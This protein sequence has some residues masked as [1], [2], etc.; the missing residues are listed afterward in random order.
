MLV[1]YFVKNLFFT[2]FSTHDLFHYLFYLKFFGL[3]SSIVSVIVCSVILAE[4][5]LAMPLERKKKIEFIVI[6]CFAV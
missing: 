2:P 3:I 1:G 5:A 4:I 6:A